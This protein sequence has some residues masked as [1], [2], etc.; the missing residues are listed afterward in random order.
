MT[1]VWQNMLWL[2]QK[3]HLLSLTRWK[4][5]WAEYILLVIRT[6]Y[7]LYVF[8]HFFVMYL[9]CFILWSCN[10]PITL[11]VLTLIALFSFHYIALSVIATVDLK[12]VFLCVSAFIN[13]LIK[14]SG[15]IR[16]LYFATICTWNLSR[17]KCHIMLKYW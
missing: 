15:K 2:W 16:L 8:F 4:T 10:L 1:V 11:Y 6:T 7:Q 3:Y 14:W 13:I 12:L 17:A 9:D 5:M